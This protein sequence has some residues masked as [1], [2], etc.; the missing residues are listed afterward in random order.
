MAT[1]I[2]ADTFDVRFPT[3][4]MLEGSDA[5]NPDQDYS[6]AGPPMVDRPAVDSDPIGAQRLMTVTVMVMDGDVRQRISTA[7]E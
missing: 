4:A 6:A 7:T 1:I 5:M 3:S 2:G